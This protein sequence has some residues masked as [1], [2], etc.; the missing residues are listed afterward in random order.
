VLIP[1][2]NEQHLM[3]DKEIVDACRKGLFHVFSVSTIDEGM[4]ILSGLPSGTR[5]AGGQYPSGSI[6]HGVEEKLLAFA[7]TRRAFLQPVIR[8]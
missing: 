7:E 2:A 5:A 1:K 8:G 3:L 6:N 4:E